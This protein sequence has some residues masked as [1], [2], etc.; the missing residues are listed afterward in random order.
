MAGV[1]FVAGDLFVDELVVRL[2]L[3]ET[4]DD[5]V[6]IA[7]GVG[8]LEVVRVAARVGV[9]DDVEPVAAVAFAVAGRGQETVDE[10]V[11]GLGGFV[12]EESV[13][14][15]GVGGR[16][17]RSKVTRRM[18]VRRSARGA[19]DGRKESMVLPGSN[20]RTGRK[21]QRSSSL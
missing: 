16:P 17:G 14:L 3:I 6:A 19:G 10:F 1:E 4:A 5:V 12:G 8:A 18:R 7:P 13:D 11:P 2:V 20:G 21:A 9:A 15:L